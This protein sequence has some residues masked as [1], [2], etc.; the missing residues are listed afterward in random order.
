MSEFAFRIGVP[1]DA[2]AVS[3][4]VNVA[5]E[6][7]RFFVEGDRTSPQEVRALME[8][9]TF[10][11]AIAPGE[12]LVGCV[13]VETLDGL[14]A[15]GMLAVDPA[16]Q[17]RGLGWR[18]VKAAEAHA[19]AANCSAMAIHVVNVRSDLFPFYR[20]LGYRETGATEPYVHRPTIR[21]CYFVIMRKAL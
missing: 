16:A 18:L 7:E 9:G 19:R 3:R 11:V 10:L 17:G 14:G 1:G 5:Y 20:R 21:P 8:Q 6:A 4:V 2:D 13:Y 12:S 15:F